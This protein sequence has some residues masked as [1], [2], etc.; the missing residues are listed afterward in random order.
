MIFILFFTILILNYFNKILSTKEM[1]DIPINNNS[2]S[3]SST[4][5]TF[6]Y[7]I[8]STIKFASVISIILLCAIYKFQNKLLY[9]PNPPG[10]PP[11]PDSNPVGLRRPSE[12][13]KKGNL[14]SS[15]VEGIKYQEHFVTTKDGEK[16]HLWLLLH[17]ENYDD[18]A[19]KD[20]PTII[21]FHGNAGN[22]GFRLGNIVRMFA[23]SGVNVLAMDYRGYG[24]STGK[25]TEQGLMADADA[26]VEFYKSHEKLKTSK[27]VVFGRSLGGAVAFYLAE[28]Y[29]DFIAGVVVENTFTSIADMV[30]V[31]MP[32]L[33]AK[34]KG[35]VLRIGWNS[36]ERAKKI[37]QP[38]FLISG[39]S[40]EL[41]PVE[42]MNRLRR[43]LVAS[44]LAHVEF[45]SVLGGRHNDTWEVAGA[46]YYEV[47]Y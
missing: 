37:K 28:K 47:S 22:M 36:E 34:I 12:W 17:Q 5:S 40:D 9:I 6:Y 1:E 29:P 24:K 43:A 26:I 30:D 15:E 13:D 19:L 35:L 27:P 18:P 25:P 7:L 38:V 32:K 33:L 46:L 16:I 45:W 11:T 20:V 3:S 41:V 23:R 39:D 10:F 8:I 31:I 44:G 21:Y 4:T 14:A 2:I 42:Q